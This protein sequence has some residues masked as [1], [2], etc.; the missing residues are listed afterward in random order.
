MKLKF[1]YK[2]CFYAISFLGI[3]GYFVVNVIYGEPILKWMIQENDLS[4]RFGDYFVHSYFSAIP[5][6]LYTRMDDAFGCFPPLAYILYYTLYRLTKINV[7]LPT[8]NH[9]AE[10]MEGSLLIFLYFV[11]TIAVLFFIAILISSKSRNILK[12]CLLFACLMLSAPFIGSGYFVGNSVILVLP[13]LLL[14]LIWKDSSSI[15]L[16]EIALLLIA[17]SA[18][19]KIYPAV[20]GLLYLKEK[21]WKE[22]GRLLIYGILFFFIP[23]AYFGGFQGFLLWLGHIKGTLGMLEYGRI[24]YIKGVV[25]FILSRFNGS[26]SSVAYMIC[27]IASWLFLLLM[28]LLAFIS[29]NTYRTYLF[30][31]SL[32][33]FYPTNAFRYTLCYLSIPLIFWIQNDRIDSN[34]SN[35]E[36]YLYAFF[37]GMLFSIPTLWGIVTHFENTFGPYSMTYVEV[38]LYVVAYI[39]LAYTVILEIKDIM[40]RKGLIPCNIN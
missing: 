33:T 8:N 1:D 27:S 32:M 22:V 14:T 38:H 18:G 5:N 3:I 13:L 11:I 4:I 29:R 7:Y 23:F 19:L 31:A 12:S 20:F 16:R 28:V 15:I 21:R 35:F 10:N 40:L 37:Y 25:Y 2:T 34:G 36:N 17:I 30:L 26:D 6:E 39:L 24:E 9:D